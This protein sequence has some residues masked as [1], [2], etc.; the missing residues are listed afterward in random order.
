MSSVL[1]HT[2]LKY[3]RVVRNRGEFS[4]DADG[5]DILEQMAELSRVMMVLTAVPKWKN[6]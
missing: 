4:P 1:L 6:V 5:G 2:V 3:R